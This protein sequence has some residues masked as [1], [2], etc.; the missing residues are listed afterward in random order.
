MSAHW[1]HTVERMGYELELTVA[2]QPFLFDPLRAPIVGHLRS[3]LAGDVDTW[4]WTL[5]LGVPGRAPQRALLVGLA[6]VWAFALVYCARR[7][8]ASIPK[9]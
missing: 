5:W 2:S 7:L 8:R 3:L 1:R 6:L 9:V 4:A